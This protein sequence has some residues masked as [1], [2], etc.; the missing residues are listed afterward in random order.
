MQRKITT[1]SLIERITLFDAD[2]FPDSSGTTVTPKAQLLVRAGIPAAKIS[3]LEVNVRK[4]HQLGVEYHTIDSGCAAAV[5][6]VRL[7]N[8]AMVTDPNVRSM[9]QANTAIRDQLASLPLPSCGSFT[10]KD[11]LAP[12]SIQAFCKSNQATITAILGRD[13]NRNT[14]LLWF[15]NANDIARFGGY[16]FDRGISAHHFFVAELAH[17]V[18]E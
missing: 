12:T 5:G 4:T 3:V 8:D 10:S 14:G 7:I 18:T 16:K 1:L 11:P 6:Y 9:V 15:I 13:G 2:E 17:E